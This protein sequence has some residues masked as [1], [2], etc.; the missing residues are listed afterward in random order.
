[1]YLW[2]NINEEVQYANKH[3][4]LTTT[5]NTRWLGA[6]KLIHKNDVHLLFV[7]LQFHSSIRYWETYKQLNPSS[8]L[9]RKTIWSS[10]S[11]NPWSYRAYRFTMFTEP[12]WEDWSH[13]I[14]MTVSQCIII[15]T[16][17]LNQGNLAF[18]VTPL[19]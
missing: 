18:C 4:L 8:H 16:E 7:L 17:G 1:M 5:P 10:K 11:L 3:D 2:N 9:L 15:C 12:W 6:H 13:H 14:H 19:Y